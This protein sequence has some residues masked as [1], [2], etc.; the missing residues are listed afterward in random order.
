MTNRL[1]QAI[2]DFAALFPPMFRP[3]LKR[4][5]TDLIRALLEEPKG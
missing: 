5:L 1:L 3:S 2:D 4:A